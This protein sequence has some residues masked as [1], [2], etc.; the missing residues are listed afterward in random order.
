VKDLAVVRAV[1]APVG[2]EDETDRLVLLLRGRE[3]VFIALPLSRRIV[4]IAARMRRDRHRQRQAGRHHE[5]EHAPS[6]EAAD[7][8]VVISF[9]VYSFA[10]IGASV[11][12][13]RAVGS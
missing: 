5:R 3:A 12:G 4:P 10:E 2:V 7:P 13:R 11:D 1:R 9:I 8:V 6:I